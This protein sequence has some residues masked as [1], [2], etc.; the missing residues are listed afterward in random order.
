MRAADCSAHVGAGAARSDD[1]ARHHVVYRNGQLR[2]RAGGGVFFRASLRAIPVPSAVPRAA[3]Q[4]AD[5]GS[6]DH[7]QHSAAI[8][9]AGVGGTHRSKGDGVPAAGKP[10]GDL[11]GAGADGREVRADDAGR[12][13]GDCAALKEYDS[14]Y[15]KLGGEGERD[16]LAEG[17]G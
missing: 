6:Q 8:G 7:H 2:A 11:R 13:L 14:G 10:G 16:E 15:W 3:A 9:H 12:G 5:G 1:R 4:G 17:M